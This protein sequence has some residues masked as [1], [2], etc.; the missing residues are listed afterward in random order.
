MDARA[1]KGDPVFIV[2]REHPFDDRIEQM[3]D[4]GLFCLKLLQGVPERDPPIFQGIGQ[5]IDFQD[6]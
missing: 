6:R 4:P 2:E 5:L 3:F 1:G